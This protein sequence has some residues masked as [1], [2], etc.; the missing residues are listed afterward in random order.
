MARSRFVLA[1]MLGFRDGLFFSDNPGAMSRRRFHS[2][3]KD[4]GYGEREAKAD[5]PLDHAAKMASSAN[6][7]I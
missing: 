3:G 6:L 1:V 7:S 5:Q 4:E 2:P